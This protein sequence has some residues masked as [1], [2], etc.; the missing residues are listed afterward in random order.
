MRRGLKRS[1][2][3]PAV[4]LDAAIDS[5]SVF[6]ID[7]RDTATGARPPAGRPSTGRS[8]CVPTPI[9]DTGRAR[10]CAR[11][12]RRRA[13]SAKGTVAAAT[14]RCVVATR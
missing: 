8:T 1:G 4:A 6:R 3:V 13:R 14:I 7:L 12:G 2:T 11:R 10:S 9:V 5:G